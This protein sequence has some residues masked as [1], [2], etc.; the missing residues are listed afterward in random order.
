VKIARLINDRIVDETAPESSPPMTVVRR[1]RLRH[2]H[3]ERGVASPIDRIHFLGF[4][5]EEITAAV[6]A[7]DNAGTYVLA[8]LY[9]DVARSRLAVRCGVHSL[10][11]GRICHRSKRFRDASSRRARRW[12]SARS[13]WPRSI[14]CG[15]RRAYAHHDAEGPML[16]S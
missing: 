10:E 4:S 11:H 7:A 9:T 3:S 5:R 15:W 13:P 8:H 6:E 12:E 1:G 16:R 2:G 14:R